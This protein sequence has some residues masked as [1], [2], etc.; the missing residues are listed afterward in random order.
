MADLDVIGGLPVSHL[1]WYIKSSIFSG[2]SVSY[3]SHT[4][5][6]QVVMKELLDA[7]LLHGD[8]ITVTGRTVAENLRD[9][10]KLSEI[11]AQVGRV[12]TGVR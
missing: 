8:C 11:G 3:P 2:C 4:H 6:R 1:V 12:N 7:G 5:T 9:V 10:P